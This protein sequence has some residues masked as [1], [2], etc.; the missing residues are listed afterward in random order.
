M[1]IFEAT[2][3]WIQL[4]FQLIENPSASFLTREQREDP[5]V[6]RRKADICA[7]VQSAI[8]DML[9]GPLQKAVKE[10]G[11]SEVAIA[12]GVS[13]NS[14]LRQRLAFASEEKGWTV[15]VPPMA[16]CTDNA[17]MIAAVGWLDAL[18]QRSGTLTDAPSP[19]L[20][21]LV[22]LAMKQT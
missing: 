12:G 17:A 3:G 8:L 7:S 6:E 13:A 1:F 15:H 20:P 19:R 4:E 2:H 18:E 11:I 14:G 5:F 21:E 22:S 10:T 9:M 16:Y